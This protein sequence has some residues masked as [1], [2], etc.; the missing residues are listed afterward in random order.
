[1]CSRML[2]MPELSSSIQDISSDSILFLISAN[3]IAS[4]S[5]SASTVPRRLKCLPRRTPIMKATEKLPESIR[6]AAVHQASSEA[7]MGWERLCFADIQEISAN[8]LSIME[9]PGLVNVLAA[10]DSELQDVE[11]LNGLEQHK[12]MP[13]LGL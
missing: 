10:I 4:V 12:L 2:R 8:H 5:S 11:R 1:M 3:F 6:E 13:M 7:M 9:V